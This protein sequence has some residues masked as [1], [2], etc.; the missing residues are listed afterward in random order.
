M[1]QYVLSDYHVQYLCTTGR[2]RPFPRPSRFRV[3]SNESHWIGSPRS[4]STLEKT[5]S[6]SETTVNLLEGLDL[7]PGPVKVYHRV[8][9]AFPDINISG[10]IPSHLLSTVAK[11]FSSRQMAWTRAAKTTFNVS[12][13]GVYQEHLVL[14]EWPKHLHFGSELHPWVRSLEDRSSDKACSSGHHCY[15]VLP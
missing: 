4:L 7:F 9:F 1:I 14:S 5:L 8:G 10:Y 13:E 3:L 2:D 15:T 12:K 11:T 6:S